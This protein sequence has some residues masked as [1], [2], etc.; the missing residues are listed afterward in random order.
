MP[1]FEYGNTRLRAMRTRL[2]SAQQLE[3]LAGLNRVEA[4]VDALLRGP[5]KSALER[6]LARA[7]G[8]QAIV[9]GLRVDLIESSEMVR[10][11][12]S[13]RARELVELLWR[14][15]DVMV[16]KGLLRGVQ[17]GAPPA[18][19]EGALLPAGGLTPPL[20]A[21]LARA[22][23]AYELIDRL[24]TLGQPTAEPLVALRARTPRPDLLQM[25]LA[26]ER[27]YF[28]HAQRALSSARRAAVSLRIWIEIQ[29]DLTNLL[30]VLQLADSRA[31]RRQARAQLGERNLREMLVG[32]GQLSLARLEAAAQQDNPEQAAQSLIA[33]AY[34]RPL[35][36]GLEQYQRQRR[37]TAWELQLKRYQLNWAAGR[38]HRDPL[39]M[40]VVI[41][42]LALKLNELRNLRRIAAGIVLGTP[43]S[44]IRRGLE[45]IA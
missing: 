35:A 3:Q 28:D 19:I 27:W 20:A 18:E 32:P 24:A 16:V 33:S 14:R 37:L 30:V 29:A 23:D 10:E 34:R 6:L 21:E 44:R 11:F 40:G 12:F 38:I 39:G 13:G 4:L 22:G 15:F 41:G 42:Y 26:L 5:Y 17:Q 9:A 1:S 45:L 7:S 43:P 25:D 36:Q 2:L 31:A 8:H